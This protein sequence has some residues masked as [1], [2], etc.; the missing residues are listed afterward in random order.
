MDKRW[1]AA[2]IF[3]MTSFDQKLIGGSF[4]QFHLQK[5]QGTTPFQNIGFN[6]N[7]LAYFCRF[8]VTEVHVHRHPIAERF[9][10]GRRQGQGGNIVNQ[11]ST[12]APM[13]CPA[14]VG[15]LL[16][17]HQRGHTAANVSLHKLAL[18]TKELQFYWR[19]HG[20]F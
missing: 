3:G 2:D 18:I 7:F 4:S 9:S 16:V 14:P 19:Y 12:E 8:E 5:G 13:K 11:E 10:V 20:L 1:L 15:V 17:N 6:Q